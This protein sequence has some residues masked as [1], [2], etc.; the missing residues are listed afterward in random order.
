METK[1]YAPGQHGVSRRRSKQ[2][3][4]GSQLREKQKVK[5]MYGVQEKQFRLT[6]NKAAR[7]KG[8][9]GANLL[10]LLERRL[11]NIVYRM[12]FARS[13]AE[14]RQMVKHSHITINGKKCNIPSALVKVEDIIAVKEKSRNVAFIKESMESAERKGLPGWLSVDPKA[15]SGRVVA[16]PKREEITIPIQEQFIVELYSR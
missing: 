16:F 11:D 15:L 9:A 4:Y 7:Q 5:R 1:P 14:A 8:K 2:S 10:I 12:G 6:F 3:E 13:L